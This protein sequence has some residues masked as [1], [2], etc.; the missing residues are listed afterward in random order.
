MV[1][2]NK[3]AYTKSVRVIK[4]LKLDML[5]KEKKKNGGQQKEK[6]GKRPGVQCQIEW[7][8]WI[9]TEQETTTV[10]L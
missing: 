6:K 10:V 8:M 7:D 1:D 4:L 5:E 9:V 2:E 3:V